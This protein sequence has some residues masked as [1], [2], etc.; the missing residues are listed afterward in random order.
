MTTDP[1]KATGKHSLSHWSHQSRARCNETSTGSAVPRPRK[2]RQHERRDERA[3]RQP[4]EPA[5]ASRW[6]T[7]CRTACQS[8]REGRQNDHHRR[9]GVDRDYRKRAP[10]AK[11]TD[12]GPAIKPRTNATPP[13]DLTAVEPKKATDND[14][15]AGDAAW[16]KHQHNRVEADKKLAEESGDR[17]EVLH[18]IRNNNSCQFQIKII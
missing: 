8:R 9:Q 1:N 2:A 10:C 12:S 4:R 6:Y 15:D 16:K 18:L 7:R 5:D 13:D 14:G 3:G 11:P 17:R